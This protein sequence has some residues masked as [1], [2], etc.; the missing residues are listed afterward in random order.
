MRV[1]CVRHGR[2]ERNARGVFSGCGT[3]GITEDQRRELS[4]VG[5]DASVFDVVYCS[6]ARR[7]T[8]TADSL[9]IPDYIEEPRLAE[10][11]FGIFEGRPTDECRR[12]HPTEFEAFQR[13][14]GAYVI[15][16]GESRARH[17][18]RVLGWLED[19]ST[20]RH[21]LAITHGGTIDFLYRMATSGELH[22]GNE[23]FA[24]PNAAL[25]EFEVSWPDVSLVSHGL[26]LMP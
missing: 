2:T 8:E 19:A 1:S 26:P 9:G 22:G 15:P 10:R 21:V 16:G 20:F 13:L 7:C 3:E 14:D 23:V 12:D 5:F 24:G 18:D 11:R 25:S 4:Q 6:P 17:L